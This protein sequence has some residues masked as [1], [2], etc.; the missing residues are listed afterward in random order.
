M[1]WKTLS[2]LYVFTFFVYR[3]GQTWAHIS[4][5]TMN[6]HLFNIRRNEGDRVRSIRFGGI[7]VFLIKMWLKCRTSASIQVVL[8]KYCINFYDLHPFKC[9]DPHFGRIK[10][11]QTID[12]HLFGSTQNT[13]SSL[14]LTEA[15]LLLRFILFSS[16]SE[17]YKSSQHQQFGSFFKKKE[18]TGQLSSIKRSERPQ[19]THRVQDGRSISRVKKPSNI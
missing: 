3:C 2:L 12:W 7:T 8:Q 14:Q 1:D 10:S 19:K 9:I 6:Y 13:K 5:K 4:L 17:T 11:N 15:S 18:Y 16:L